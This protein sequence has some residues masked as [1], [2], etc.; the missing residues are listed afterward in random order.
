MAGRP[1]LR[2]Q[3]S[4]QRFLLRRLE[5]AILARQMPT[6]RDPVRARKIAFLV[7]CGVAGIAVVLDTIL[8]SAAGRVIPSDATVVMVRQSGALFVRIDDRLRPVANLTSARLIL[9]S[10]ATPRLVDDA[11]LGDTATGPILGIPGAP[12]SFGRVMV[13]RDVRWA[14]CDDVEGNTT[15]A[16]GDDSMPLDLDPRTA[17][18]A[19]VARGDGS[20]Y[21]LYDGTRAMLDPGDPATARALRITEATLRTVSSTVL[22]TIPEV[23]AISAPRIAGMGQPSGVTGIAVGT[24]LRVVRTESPEYYVALPGGL[25]RIGR[26][27]AELIRFSDPAAQAEITDVPPELITRSPLVDTLPVG[28]Y[29]DEPPALVGAG[30]DV[31]ATWLSGHSGIAVTPHP[32]DRPGTVALAGSDG[33]GP[34]VDSVRMI[35]GASLDVTGGPGTER[36]LVTSAGVRFPVDDSVSAALGL[37]GAPAAAPWAI[38]GV[39]PAG[40]ALNR[41]AA[42]VGR[43]V[44]GAAP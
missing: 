12:A 14:V 35:P 13:P 38:V 3:L 30:V 20:A 31:C 5:Y 8:G 2:A 44:L 28:S 39:L 19:T 41:D 4:A 36:Y 18:V 43:D 7:G 42:L 25:Q 24:V 9:G 29:P 1:P 11:A 37:S 10:P 15:V 23:P 6:R 34:A 32:G 33:D 21:L 26:L 16:V 17:V 27:A 40:P 22:N